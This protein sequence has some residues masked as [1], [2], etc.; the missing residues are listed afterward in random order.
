MAM[1]KIQLEPIITMHIRLVEWREAF[2]RLEAK[3]EIKVMM[4]PNEKYMPR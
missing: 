3:Q 2:E 4:Y 1:G